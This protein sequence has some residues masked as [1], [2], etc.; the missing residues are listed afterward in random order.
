[1]E[2][3]PTDAVEQPSGLFRQIIDLLEM[4]GFYNTADKLVDARTDI[5]RSNVRM[6]RAARHAGFTALPWIMTLGY[7]GGVVALTFMRNRRETR[8]GLP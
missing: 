4:L 6:A 1:M 5:A 3:S 2:R 8:K 7:L